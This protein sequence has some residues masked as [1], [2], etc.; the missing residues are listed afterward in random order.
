MKCGNL[1]LKNKDNNYKFNSSLYIFLNIFEAHFPM[2][3]KNIGIIKNL[4][5]TQGIKI[6]CRQKRHLYLYSRSSNNPY[7]RAYYIKYHKILNRVIKEAKRQHCYGL[8]TELN[9][10][11][12]ST[13]NIIKQENRKFTSDWTDTISPLNYEKVKDL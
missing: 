8:I 10:Q 9:N 2:Q 6:S 3:N 1:F 11:I 5:I 7:M 13:W 4:W 12:K